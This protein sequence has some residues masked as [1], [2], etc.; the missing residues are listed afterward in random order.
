MPD[1]FDASM[2][3]IVNLTMLFSFFNGITQLIIL[4]R[5]V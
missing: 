3:F 1:S 2:R 4:L 5:I